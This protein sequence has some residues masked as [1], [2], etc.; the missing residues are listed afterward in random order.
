MS[1]GLP[2]TSTEHLFVFGRVISEVQGSQQVRR[3]ASWLHHSQVSGKF[4]ENALLSFLTDCN[5]K[6]R[7]RTAT[8][9]TDQPLLQNDLAQSR[10]LF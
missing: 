1:S 9:E 8:A 7:I 3:A 10:I 5:L 2:N 4:F 6:D